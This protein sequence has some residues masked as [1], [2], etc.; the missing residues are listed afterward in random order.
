MKKLIILFTSISLL[1]GCS[2]LKS[3]PTA[4]EKGIFNVQTN[5]VP[6]T[7]FVAQAFP[8]G[9]IA[10]VPQ[11]TQSTNYTLIPKPAITSTANWVGALFG[12]Y[13]TVGALALSGILGIWGRMR[14]TQASTLSA[15]A[16]NS[17]QVI[18]TARNILK[19]LPNGAQISTQFDNWMMKHQQD[20]G[21]ANE[22]AAIVD[23]ATASSQNPHADAA[24]SIISAI[25]APMNT[26]T[27]K[28]PTILV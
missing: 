14:S 15:V 12:P 17:V 4:T 26:P 20:A 9:T 11:V 21:I 24:Q 25:T 5:V 8:D 27:P 3:P 7:N 2:V 13:G 22:I 28:S 6:T 18:E 1:V 19:S 16:D 10:Q 23:E